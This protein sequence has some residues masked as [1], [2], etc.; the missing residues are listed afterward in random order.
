MAAIALVAGF[1][2]AGLA[3]TG[4]ADWIGSAA[5]GA[6]AAAEAWTG[7]ASL[8]GVRFAELKGLSEAVLIVTPSFTSGQRRGWPGMFLLQCN[9]AKKYASGAQPSSDICAPHKGFCGV[10]AL[11]ISIILRYRFGV[12]FPHCGKNSRRLGLPT[13]GERI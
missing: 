11:A 12:Y 2:S 3:A 4:A 6:G 1:V 7:S 8:R 5:F 13:G 9:M 10:A